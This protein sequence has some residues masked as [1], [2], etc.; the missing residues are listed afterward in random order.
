VSQSTVSAPVPQS[1][2]NTLAAAI[3]WYAGA[4]EEQQALLYA[5]YVKAAGEGIGAADYVKDAGEWPSL[6]EYFAD[7][8]IDEPMPAKLAEVF[9]RY[10]SAVQ[11]YAVAESKGQLKVG[12]WAQAVL[13][14][15]LKGITDLG[16]RRTKRTELVDLCQKTITLHCSASASITVDKAL[17]LNA[18]GEVFGSK[19]YP[20]HRLGIAKLR[21]FETALY[22]E[23]DAEVWGFKDSVTEEQQGKL[24]EVWAKA[25]STALSAAA[26]ADEVRIAL[27]KEIK[28]KSEPAAEKSTQAPESSKAENPA[29]PVA[30][31]AAA[32]RK[33][34]IAPEN[35][36]ECAKRMASLPYGRPDSEMVWR[37]FGSSVNLS[38][39]DAAAFVQGLADAGRLQ[40]LVTITR[41]AVELSKK[42]AAGAKTAE[43]ARAVA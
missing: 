43:A 41:T 11:E 16:Q 20:A 10:E 27:G 22:R 42:L 34:E 23:K 38:E 32:E 1:E 13:D 30:N 37:N 7:A 9:A 8:G 14:T 33:P 3:P 25:C 4:T 26:V 19:E 29:A 15:G 6:S 18:V 17:R 35:P 12:K 36:V 39:K 40:V 5:D 31:T 21:E 28:A 24:R 2:F